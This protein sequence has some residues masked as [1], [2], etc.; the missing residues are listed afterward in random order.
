MKKYHGLK[1]AKM[2]QLLLFGLF[3]VNKMIN[4]EG[5]QPRG[6]DSILEL[7]SHPQDMTQR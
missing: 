3:G 6:K 1:G 5:G 7:L 4:S 2:P